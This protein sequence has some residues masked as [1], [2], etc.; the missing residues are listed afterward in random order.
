MVNIV[1]AGA[2]YARTRG[3]EVPVLVTGA[4]S[5]AIR[6]LPARAAYAV[7]RSTLQPARRDR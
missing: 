5:H 7:M 6:L 2:T 4:I 1:L 3:K